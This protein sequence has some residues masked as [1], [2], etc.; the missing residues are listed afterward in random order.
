MGPASKEALVQTLN[1]LTGAV[2]DIVEELQ[3]L[4]S[5]LNRMSGMDALQKETIN[6]RFDRQDERLL[7]LER[8]TRPAG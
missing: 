3:A 1:S 6:E 5:V 8:A 4:R 7:A 2:G